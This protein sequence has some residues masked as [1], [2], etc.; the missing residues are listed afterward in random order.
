MTEKIIRTKYVNIDARFSNE[1]PC[2]PLSE[3]YVEL[4]EIIHNVKSLSIACIEIPISFFNICDALENNCCKI[5]DIDD[6]KKQAV[7]KIKDEY[8]TKESLIETINKELVYNNLYDLSFSLSSKNKTKISTT[9][10][11]YII[12]FTVNDQGESSENKNTIG[13]V[14][15]FNNPKYYIEPDKEKETEK[16]C[17]YLNPRYLYLEIRERERKK[18]NKINYAFESNILC[19]KMSK[20]IIARITLDY[21]TFP[22][23][24]VLPANIFNGFLISD[25]RRYKEKIR[26][27]DLEIRLLNEFG[28][29]ICFN[30]FEI[31]FCMALEYEINN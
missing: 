2:F 5:T 11:R 12:D 10:S 20:Y 21:N 29:P 15:G 24:S 1:F 7:I 9:N 30:G 6:Q 13:S 27:E 25:V 8:Y 26:L 22:Y 14:L 18:E 4:Q 16:L 19:S 28:Y 23:G 3:Y 17:N 31:S